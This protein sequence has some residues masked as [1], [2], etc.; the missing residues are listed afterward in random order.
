MK[1]LYVSYHKI[2]VTVPTPWWVSVDTFKKQIQ[3]FKESGI[4]ITLTFDDGLESFY[5]YAYPSILECKIPTIVFVISSLVG[6]NDRSF[7]PPD[8]PCSQLMNWEMIKEISSNGIVIGS[9]TRSHRTLIDLEYDDILGELSLSKSTIEHQISK[10]V[11][12][13]AYPHNTYSMKVIEALKAAG[14]KRAFAGETAEDIQYAIRRVS[15]NEK[16]DK[17]K[18]IKEYK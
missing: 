4:D 18:L 17:D 9:H 6:G 10:S 15:M 3:A 1:P 14:Y 13:F 5:T 12:D 16:T 7:Y 11:L 2:G 8:E